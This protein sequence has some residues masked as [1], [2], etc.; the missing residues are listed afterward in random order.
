MEDFIKLL[1]S[2]MVILKEEQ[3]ALVENDGERIIEIVEQ[4]E[5]FIKKLEDHKGLNIAENKKIL[6]IIEEINEMQEINLMLTNQ[7]LNFN[8]V[9]LD[10]L[11]EATEHGVSS[12]SADGKISKAKKNIINQSV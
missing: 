2:M 7:A 5:K 9:F 4:K 3:E 12:Y 11:K 8:N 6:K 1:D 10:A